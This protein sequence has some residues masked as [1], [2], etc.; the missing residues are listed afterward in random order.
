MVGRTAWCASLIAVILAT[1][2]I[3]C[4]RDT[5]TAPKGAIKVG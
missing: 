4:E 2:T 5:S 1:M 3:S